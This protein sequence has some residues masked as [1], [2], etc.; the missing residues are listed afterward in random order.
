VG[1]LWQDLRFA[2]RM[3]GKNPGFALVAVL[4][5]ALGIGANTA[6]FSLM[7]AFILRLL[8]LKDPEQLMLISE[9][10][11]KDG[12][13]RRPTGAAYQ[14][15]AKYS[16]TF[17]QIE[18]TGFRGD[19]ATLTGIGRAERVSGG[20]CGLNFFSMVGVKPFRGR[21][22]LPEDS[23]RGG[24]TAVVITENLWQRVFGADPNVVGQTVTIAGSKQTIIGILPPGFSILPW[25]MH[26]DVWSGSSANGALQFR[27]SNIVGR[28][29]PGV[30]KEQAQTELNAIAQG[31]E[32]H[33]DADREWSVRVQSLHEAFVGGARNFFRLLLGAVGFILLIAC[34]N[35]ANLLLAR[36][37]ARE[38]EIAIRASLG[39]GR[40]R[41]IRQLLAESVLLALLGGAVGTLLGF[42][43]IRVLQAMAP[44]NNV[45]RS[46]TISIDH[47]VLSYTIGIS[48]LTGILFGLIPA[49]RAVRHD[50]SESLKAGGTAGSGGLR[51]RSQG[52]L[53]VSEVGLAMV[54]LVGAG[55]MINS[56][57]R[58]RKVDLGFNPR[59][60]LRADVFLDG[61]KFWH[62]VPGQ[63]GY[64]KEI[65][66]QSDFFFHDLLERL[67]HVPG[68]VSAGI[69]HLAPPGDIEERTF[70]VIGR[71]APDQGKEPQAGYNEVSAG[72]FRSLDVPLV[73]GRYVT[74]RDM[75]GSPWV[76]DIN[77][78]MARRF[79]PNEDP[80][81]KLVL[82][83][84]QGGV[85]SLDEDR[86]REIVGVVGDVRHFGF[87]SDVLPMMYSSYQ[88]HG[89]KYP[90]GFYIFH[91]WKSITI[92]TAG[93]PMRLVAPLQKLV[94]EVD[95]DQALF[96]V[97]SIE[98]GLSESVSFDRFQMNL[99]GIFGG[100]GLALA[101]VG[102]YGVMSYLVAQRTHEIGVRVALGAGPRDVL[103]M[104]ILRGLKTT[105]IGLAVGIAASLAL[106]RLI[107][108][109]LYHVKN[110]DPAT[111][112]LVALVLMAVALV[113]CYVPA[114]RATKVDPLVALRYE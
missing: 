111:Y 78:T 97:Q 34:T 87:D 80:I 51:L 54:L 66:P 76:I 106:T 86:P 15:W 67:V 40:W 107:A 16:R 114:R 63:V 44:A 43:G 28:L 113:A 112:T 102:I 110:T 2:A 13:S 30:T 20:G 100:L 39:A 10:R 55:L 64:M 56:F 8:P 98:Q 74:E 1:S 24:E 50:L 93:D 70:R 71:P 62:N 60:V 7:N 25:D 85:A 9:V 94:A 96:R 99:F 57:V 23:P 73:R 69:S 109:F 58:L 12:E 59:N 45:F 103:R 29:K 3:L 105:T 18:R 4:T 47:R 52:L 46:L 48:V 77:E 49:F 84:L 88:Q 5:L 26:V 31:M 33:L 41:L 61:P 42:W 75:E 37:A 81:G 72:Y 83:K 53:L 21:F 27:M 89:M 17:E 82:T 91:T 104:V 65:T 95:K 101:T 19:P 36:G 35:V 79:F 11:I 14:A 108:G 32:Q 68:V 38:R 92:R 90:S 22:F 6:I